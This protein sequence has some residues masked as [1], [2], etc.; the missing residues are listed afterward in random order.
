LLLPISCGDAP[1]ATRLGPG[2]S[3][4]YH[5]RDPLGSSSL[6]L[7]STAQIVARTAHEPYGRRWLDARA[8][9]QEGSPYGF[10]DKE[11]DPISGAI[12]IGSRHYLPELGRWV[13]PD[14]LLLYEE[15][16]H[17]AEAPGQ[18][19]PYA[20]AAND[21]V[22]AIDPDGNFAQAIAGAL[23]GGA[24]GLASNVLGQFR[25]GRDI[26]WTRAAAAG[27]RGAVTGAVG[28]V[29]GPGA[30]MAVRSV[31]SAGG[32]YLDAKIAGRESSVASIAGSALVGALPSAA[33]PAT[34]ALETAGATALA[35]GMRSIADSAVQA[36]LSM[37]PETPGAGS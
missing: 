22:D 18:A 37:F 6:V 5:V 24:A 25:E 17:L 4:R 20:Y 10:A 9:G 15:P 7:D 35:S 32:T 36:T 21:P 26:D 2:A 11:E 13:S 28:A 30:A 29:A 27:V 31:V 23:V 34:S 3:T 19:N 8:A 33:G 12:Y 1:E 16:E 14:P